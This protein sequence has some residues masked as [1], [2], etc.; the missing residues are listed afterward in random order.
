MKTMPI[1]L[2]IFFSVFFGI[3]FLILGIGLY[4][5]RMSYLAKHWPTT[6]GE[7]THLEVK[8]TRDSKTTD[9][10]AVVKYRYRVAGTAYEG[11]RIAFGY[12]SSSLRS[13]H[14]EIADRLTG[15]KTVLVRYDPKNVSRSVLTYG[16]NRSTILMLVFGG[17]WT[18][19]VTGLTILCS[20]LMQSDYGILHTLVTTK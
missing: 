17:T 18:A 3:G 7:I 19:F 6:N 1:P 15:V 16:L 9:F 8:E 4:S 11:N 2:A 5:L 20:T 14:Q 12:A 13:A 10:E